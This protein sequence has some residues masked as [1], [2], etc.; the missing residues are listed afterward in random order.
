MTSSDYSQQLSAT[1]SSLRSYSASVTSLKPSLATSR[2]TFLSSLRSCNKQQASQS[3]ARTPTTS[4]C[5]TTLS[6][7]EKVSWTLGAVLSW[8]CALAIKPTYS[9]LTLTASSNYCRRSTRM[10]TELKHC[11]DRAWALLG[12][13]GRSITSLE[14]PANSSHSDISEAFPNG[15]VSQYY[16]NDWLTQMC[17][18]T[19]ANKEFSPRTQETARWAREQIKRQAGKSLRLHSSC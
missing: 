10:Q 19:R 17:R 9:S 5:L 7:Y 4:R 1:S 3:R 12:K 13:W 16:R 15:E 11:L 14:Y 2:P 8:L 18:E 6:V